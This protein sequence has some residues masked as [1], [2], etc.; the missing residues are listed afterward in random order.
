V[1]R[2]APG[3]LDAL[4]ALAGVELVEQLG[5]GKFQLLAA[6]EADVRAAVAEALVR[7]GWG[8][9]ELTSAGMSLEEIFLKLTREDPVVVEESLVEQP[10][11]VGEHA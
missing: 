1:A 5:E 4:S 9:Q 10:V 2:P 8:L 7:G 3:I 11:E 6:S